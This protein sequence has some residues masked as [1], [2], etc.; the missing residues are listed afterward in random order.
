MND[1]E[2]LQA[3]LQQN[4]QD[5]F[6]SL[7]ERYVNLV[8]SA[9]WRQTGQSALAEDITQAVF[10]ILARKA[11][12]LRAQTILPGWLFRTT[13]HV[14]LTALRTDQRRRHREQLALDLSVAT[15]AQPGLWEEALPV[16]DDVLAQLGEV[17]RNAVL[18][19]F[20]QRKNLSE[21]GVE[22]GISEEA[23]KKRVARA[24]EKLRKLFVARGIVL[25]GAALGTLLSTGTVRSAPADLAGKASASAFLKR[26]GL[27]VSA[28][29]L[30]EESLRRAAVE[31]AKLALVLSGSL[32]AVSFLGTLV[33]QTWHR[34]LAPGQAGRSAVAV[35]APAAQTA[36][37]SPK[38]AEAVVLPPDLPLRAL[39][40][41][42]GQPFV[43]LPVQVKYT[44]SNVTTVALTTDREGLCRIP[45][46]GHAFQTLTATVGPPGYVPK[47]VDWFRYE[48]ESR[49]ELKEY[50]LRL[51]PGRRLEGEVRDPGGQ[52]VARAHLSVSFAV[53]DM[54]EREQAASSSSETDA[55]GLW[56][57]DQLPLGVGE[58][59]LTIEHPEF[60]LLHTNLVIKD[61][62]MVKPVLVLEPG[63]SVAGIVVDGNGGAI[64]GAIVTDDDTKGQLSRELSTSSTSDG[65]FFFPHVSPGKLRLVARAEGYRPAD[66]ELDLLSAI[67]G[68]RLVLSPVSKTNV[69]LHEVVFDKKLHLHGTVV[70]DATGQPIPRFKVVF[71]REF[72]SG[73][74][75]P[76][77][78]FQTLMG[79]PRFL[80]EGYDGQFDWNWPLQNPELS[81]FQF[82][83]RA[84]GYAPGISSSIEA[85]NSAAALAFRLKRGDRIAGKVVTPDGTPAVGANVYEAGKDLMPTI[86]ADSRQPLGLAVY[87]K[88]DPAGQATTDAQGQFSVK[89]VAGADRLIVLHDSGCRIIRLE[90]LGSG[91]VVL[92]EW[93]QIQGQ[94][95]VGNAPGA[96]QA[97]DLK[98]AWTSADELRIPFHG[99]GGRTD[100]QGRFALDRVPPGKYRAYQVVRLRPDGTGP[101]GMMHLADVSV[102]PGAVSQLTL[103][104]T[105]RKVTG[106][107]EVIPAGR[108]VDWSKDLQMLTAKGREAL[109]P[110]PESFP[111]FLAYTE[112]RF[113]AQ[114][115]SY[116]VVN[117]NGTFTIEDVPPGEYTVRLRLTAPM[118]PP[119]PG[120]PA[121]DPRHEIGSS[122]I[123]IAVPPAPDEANAPAVDLG[124]IP[125]EL[126]PP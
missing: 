123:E 59:Y 72:V 32:V 13:R 35:A 34:N 108:R 63:V 73:H 110:P 36:A 120:Y 70:D 97:V 2:L 74:L 62:R 54:A 14:A 27:A 10:T 94:L 65:L 15:S 21:V 91:Q 53:W 124:A 58:I 44:G 86:Q 24:I 45:L 43:R 22:L 11:H 100:D 56:I 115:H 117:A 57:L 88:T 69:P 9:A 125:I 25:S 89:P 64:W 20:F 98:I 6:R 113:D 107:V 92:Q 17:D 50:S 19:R 30:V 116:F 41:D 39:A 40:A 79:P 103:G 87:P 29:V 112:A 3:Y 42:S 4:S 90:E 48:M 68:I 102:Q 95:R 80:G 51:D 111:N 105:G 38:A 119:P 122:S 18:L 33:W 49:R 12:T 114:D 46:A 66:K 101:F 106:H 47:T 5:A 52:P 37:A 31:K 84:P 93:G 16:L 7:V 83:V 76:V 61:A 121:A 96:N 1:W 71:G 109:L 81:N 28:L 118:V 77:P 26:S 55:D 67:D 75:Q 23:A 60:A 78:S 8:Y 99:I 82:E 104:G 85:S 126:K